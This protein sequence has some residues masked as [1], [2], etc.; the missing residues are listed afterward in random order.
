MKIVLH[1]RVSYDPRFDAFLRGLLAR[2]IVLFCAVGVDC[3][4]WEE[5]MDWAC[6]GPAGEALGIVVTT[7][8]PGETVAE[9]VEFAEMFRTD[10]PSVVEIIEL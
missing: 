6:I 5:A 2:K 9:V 4:A 3:A 1:T 10:A 8:H 7:S